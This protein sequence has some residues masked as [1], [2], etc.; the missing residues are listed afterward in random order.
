MKLKSLILALIFS[1]VSVS[2]LV[3]EEKKEGAMGKLSGKAYF[4]YTH[5][6]DDNS[7][8]DRDGKFTLDRVYVT[9]KKSIGEK[10]AARVTVDASDKTDA[11]EKYGEFYVKYAYFQYKDEFV[12]I[13]SKAQVGLIGTPILGL[14]DKLGGMRWITKNALDNKS[15][16]ASADLG[17]SLALDFMGFATLTAAVLNGDG[18]KQITQNIDNG[19]AVDGLLSITPMKGLYINGFARYHDNQESDYSESYFGGGA[20]WKG[21][22]LKVGG[23]FTYVNDTQSTSK[24]GDSKGMII[25]AWV[26]SN[27]DGLIGLPILAMTR[28][29]YLKPDTGNDTIEFGIGSGYKFNKNL[30][31][32]VWFDMDKEDGSDT[33]MNLS[34]KFE[35]KY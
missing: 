21:K 25:D 12:G 1:V 5:E 19:V 20:A 10:L 28:V 13:K 22:V 30:Q 32:L 27:L 24:L 2:A 31:S 4:Q 35:F 14:T 15:I 7:D 23:N 3:A 33:N 26:N 29:V 8:G 34:V 9:W 17:A 6:L 18:Y 16:E 11:G